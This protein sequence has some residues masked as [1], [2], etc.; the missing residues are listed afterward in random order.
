MVGPQSCRRVEG[1]FCSVEARKVKKL[2]KVPKGTSDY[3]ASWIAEEVDGDAESCED[4]EDDDDDDDDEMMDDDMEE[5]D[6]DIDSQV[7]R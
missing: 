7:S 4:D 2:M 5:D 3:Q 1:I 6:E